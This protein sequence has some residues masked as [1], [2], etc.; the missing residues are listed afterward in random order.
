MAQM[1]PRRLPREIRQNPLRSAECRV[2]DCFESL[3]DHN[4]TVFYSRP[5]LGLSSTGDEIEGEADFVVA[6]ADYGYLSIEVKGGQIRYDPGSEKWTSTDRNGITRVIKNPVAQARTSKHRI[7]ELLLNSP[8]WTA[9]RICIRHGVICTDTLIPDVDYGPDRPR[10]I[11][12]DRRE[13]TT[14]LPAWVHG[15]FRT[16]APDDTPR[17]TAPLGADGLRA[18]TKLLADPFHLRVPLGHLMDDDD[19][20]IEVLTQRQFIILS[21]VQ[22]LRRIA[23]RGGAGTGKTVLAVEAARRAADRGEKTLFT[24]FNRALARRLSRRMGTGVDVRS[25]HSLCGVAANQAGLTAPPGISGQQ[26][27]DDV[28]PELLADAADLLPAFRYDTIV[29]DEG[30]D[31]RAHWW[32]A[33]EPVLTPQGRLLVFYDSNQRLYGNMAALPKDLAAHPIPL[34]QNLRNTDPIHHMAMR[35]YAGEP[36]LPNG[37]SGLPVDLHVLPD[38]A[39]YRKE[40]L[41]IVAHLADVEHVAPDD[42]AILCATEGEGSILAPTGLVGR[43]PVAP[44]DDPVAGA[45]TMDT[46]RRFK[47]LDCR[48]VIVIATKTLCAEPELAYVA[49]SRARSHLIGIGDRKS[50]AALCLQAKDTS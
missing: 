2:F 45:L 23:V 4:W 20:E 34:N 49:I 1:W 26:L 29:V 27:H 35:H 31:F 46:V 48:V 9:R 40:L 41:E 16:A 8:H 39:M 42:I 50:L 15:R 3:F 7:L 43:V 19:Q 13:F 10:F 14:D 18:L 32:L 30:Q 11:F 33:L 28:L 12:A 24:C 44:C 37:I 36:V 22:D 6:H 47:G 21:A 25:F 5:W 38:P 17:R